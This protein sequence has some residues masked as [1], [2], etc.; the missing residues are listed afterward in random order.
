MV[1]KEAELRKYIKAWSVRNIVANLV[2]TGMGFQGN[3]IP[4]KEMKAIQRISGVE[5]SRR[6]RETNE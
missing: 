5:L 4:I 1:F 2:S 6:I 3:V